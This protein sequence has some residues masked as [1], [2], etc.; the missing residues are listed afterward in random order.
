MLQFN[1]QAGAELFKIKLIPADARLFAD[2]FCLIPGKCFLA[3]NIKLITDE[4]PL[5][6][7]SVFV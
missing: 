2:D 3:H 7:A 6:V 5:A 1:T 4:P